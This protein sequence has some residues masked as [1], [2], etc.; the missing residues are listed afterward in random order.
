M[1]LHIKNF[2]KDPDAPSYVSE[3]STLGLT[4]GPPHLLHVEGMNPNKPTH[5]YAFNLVS[6]DDTKAEY[7]AQPVPLWQGD[8]RPKLT[9]LN[10]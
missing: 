5:A 3:A 2:T 8:N 7:I 1:A 4:A 10:S 9:I 6:K